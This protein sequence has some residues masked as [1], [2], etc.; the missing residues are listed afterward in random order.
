MNNYDFYK[1]S[2]EM[3]AY[4]F[5]SAYLAALHYANVDYTPED[6][7]E[8][9]MNYLKLMNEERIDYMGVCG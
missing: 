5:T 4:G 6:E 8:I 3:L 7:D 1:V 9:Y 2:P